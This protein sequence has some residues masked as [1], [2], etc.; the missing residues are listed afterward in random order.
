MV[1]SFQGRPDRATQQTGAGST[2]RYAARAA[3][4]PDYRLRGN[5]ASIEPNTLQCPDSEV[6]DISDLVVPAKASL[7]RA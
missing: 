1:C 5:D 2:R 4:A 6:R 7:S 3:I